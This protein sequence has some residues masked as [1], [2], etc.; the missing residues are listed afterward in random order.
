MPAGRDDEVLFILQGVRRRSCLAT[1]GELILPEFFAGFDVEGAQVE[2]HRREVK[3]S[4]PA[5]MIGPPRLIEPVCW[6]GTNE[7]SGTSQTCLP[8][9]RS[10]AVVVPHGGALQGK[11]LG[12]KMKVR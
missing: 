11:L 9:K 8:E 4:P 7:P 6:P 3:T 2:V 10:T 12:E 1:R 5:V